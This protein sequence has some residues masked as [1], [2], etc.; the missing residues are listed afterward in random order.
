MS[1]T[2]HVTRSVFD[3]YNVVSEDDLREAV[4]L[5]QAHLDKQPQSNVVPL[6][7]TG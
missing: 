1:I 3:R 2:G 4:E 5:Q 7:R 6:P